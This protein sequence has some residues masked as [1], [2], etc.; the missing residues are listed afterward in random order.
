[1]VKVIG[2]TKNELAP[3]T[4]QVDAVDLAVME[5]IITLATDTL[6]FAPHG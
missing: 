5:R 4:V 2:M 1:V 3:A 6:K